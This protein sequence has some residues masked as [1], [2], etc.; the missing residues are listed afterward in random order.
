MKTKNFK[1]GDKAYIII[2]EMIIECTIEKIT[3]EDRIKSYSSKGIY[4]KPKWINQEKLNYLINY[5]VKLAWISYID[6]K[7]QTQER[8]EECDLIKRNANE[9]VEFIIN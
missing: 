5:P 4:Q 8:W 7:G 2:N 9:F 6:T 3:T 1:K